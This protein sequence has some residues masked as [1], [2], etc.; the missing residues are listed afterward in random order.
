MSQE[1]RESFRTSR[2]VGLGARK[3]GFSAARCA[4]P[5]DTAFGL[6]GRECLE[7]LDPST[8][9]IEPRTIK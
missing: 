4:G 1:R 7:G 3:P 6:V 5:S 9:G 2:P 8:G